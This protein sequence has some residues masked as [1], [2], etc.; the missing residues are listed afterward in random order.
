[1]ELVNSPTPPSRYATAVAE[2]AVAVDMQLAAFA[3]WEAQPNDP[4]NRVNYDAVSEYRARL[5]GVCASLLSVE[6]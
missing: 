2:H 3:A 1:M 4:A 5:N 6:S